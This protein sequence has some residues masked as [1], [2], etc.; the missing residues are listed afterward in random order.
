[1]PPLRIRNA[2]PLWPLALVAALGV[3]VALAGCSRSGGQPGG[4]AEAS[5][6]AV[7]SRPAAPVPVAT[8]VPAR[9]DAPLRFRHLT[10]DDGLSQNA[11]YATLQDRRGFFWFGTKDGL[12]RY[13]GYEFAVYRHDAA[14][15]ATLSSSQI[16][17][18]LED[19]E[20]LLWVG[21]H[22]GGLNR[23]DR[24]T[25]A[26]VR[27]ANSPQSRITA[28]AE[29]ARGG[30]WLGTAGEGVARLD[31]AD[32]GAPGAPFARLR[33]DP[34]DPGSLSHDDVNA[35]LPDRR[36]ALWIGTQAGLNR[37]GPGRDVTRFLPRAG[38]AGSLIDSTVS[39]LAQTRDG[40]LWV[41]TPRGLSRL[42]AGGR[43]ASA[44]FPEQRRGYGWASVAEIAEGPGGRLWL[45]THDGLARFD[46]PTGAY[47]FYRNGRSDPASVSGDF[48][49][50]VLWD[51]TGVLWA[52]TAGYGLNRY[53]AKTARFE[54]LRLPPD[55]V[56]RNDGFSVRSILEDTAGRVWIGAGVLYRVDPATGA[57]VSFETTSA[58]PADFGNARV[59]SMI[60][61]RDGAL[62]FGSVEGLYRLDPATERVRR[63]AV[64]PA[65]PG[66]LPGKD[67]FGVFEDRA[68]RIWAVT[69]YHLSRL[70]D[71]DS[72]R[73]TTFRHTPATEAD[74]GE[75]LFPSV[76]ED[77]AGRFWMATESGLLRLDPRTG[78]SRRF[79][80]DPDDPASLSND[81]V[82][83]VCPDP[84]APERVLWI[85]TAGGGLDRLDVRTGTFTH[86]TERDGLPNTVVYGVL[87]DAAGHLWIST[88]R[89]L[90]RYDPQTGGVRTYDVSD[91]LQSNE[92]N[93]GA[94]SRGPSGRLYFGGIN[95][96]T[97]FDPA[98]LADNPVAPAV[99]LTGLRVGNR[100]VAVGDS[101]GLLARA[102]W[103]TET[104]RLSPSENMVTFA[105]AALDASAPE[106]NRYAYRMEGFDA[107]WI[108]A[109]TDRT[110][111]YTNLPPGRYT[112]R[113]RGSN[114]DGVWNERGAALAIAVAPPW[115]RTW[116]AL[117][118]YA[119]LAA[120]ALRAVA[121]ER[122]RRLDL[123]HLAR[124][125]HAEAE[126]LRALDRAKSAF[127]ANVSHEFRTPLTLTL[128]PLDDAL[129]GEYGPVPAALAEPLGLARRSASRVLDLIGQILDL[130][131]LEAG[132]TPLHAR[133][134]D[135]AAFAAAQAQAFAPL[136][137]H[138]RIT[139]DVALPEAP[140]V[141]WFDPDHVGTVLT[142]VLS[143]A[144]KFTP[145]G[146]HVRVTVAQ[147]AREARVTV[148][149]TGPGIAPEDL[150]RVFDRFFQAD[151]PS[152]AGRP[153]GSGI[154]L[155][156]A[157]DLAALHGGT[158]TAESAAGRGSAFTLA[159]PRG[160]AH[161]TPAQLRLDPWDGTVTA[162][163][164]PAPAARTAG[165]AADDTSDDDVTTVLVADDN[166]DIRAYLR[167]HLEAAGYRV[168]EAAD[169]EEAL[170]RARAR[171][172]DLVVSDVMMPRLD[173]LGLCRALRGDPETD[174]VPVLLLTARATVEDRLDGL[175]E[176][177][178]DYLTKPFDVRELVA[179]VGN[180]IALRQRL[181]DRFAG[182][183][184]AG[185]GAAVPGAPPS[186]ALP[187]SADGTF[188]A[189]VRAAIEAHLGDDAFDVAALAREVGQ[190]RGSLLRRTT[191]LLGSSPSDLIRTTRLDRARAL[192]AARAG[193][194]S[195]VAYA[196]GFKSVAHFSNAFL[197]HTGS[198]P[199]AC[200]ARTP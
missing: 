171:L 112:F 141:V 19:R 185:D 1:M 169:G 65:R 132:R 24:A 161:L 143:N 179:R 186:L 111:T 177:C 47:T 60:Q 72:G 25:G 52:S 44:P 96:V 175:A 56:A 191:A 41:G 94:F 15:P 176:A 193:T 108:D 32:V 102:L 78:R 62:W 180:L 140:V 30:L 61:S 126:A 53:D 81:R 158:L 163:D 26:V 173:G 125:E 39:A 58:R 165:T 196:V 138:C 10:I 59:W 113:V 133:Q 139:T 167:R 145:E 66:G 14:A 71:A 87:P 118:L 74:A 120:A 90:A 46:P 89:G 77:A 155:A 69:R 34:G 7:A 70:D 157:H 21:T 100:P 97:S 23:L 148:R 190:S 164:P 189:A 45:A 92:F 2:L 48:L 75:A 51:R 144:F 84:R 93:A 119:G 63:Y 182:D 150:A 82:R 88:N 137:A 38:D 18:L 123:R 54:T 36:G 28:I 50:G 183:G 49:T 35:L 104:L 178:D 40:T 168:D 22:D 31:R 83:A 79:R 159:L 67:V 57:F 166:A 156:L 29:D 20:G 136:A 85:G 99:V 91:G 43:F 16:T 11:V 135:L 33:H 174:F 105:F 64:D 4:G 98:T 9:A 128:G 200:A 160:H 8:S 172:P 6:P 198:R 129:A 147:D 101:T 192:L 122:R 131:R 103:D 106:K 42:T 27:Y 121:R 134:A 55:V 80:A 199:S 76:H 95:G 5:R 184:A 194:V 197:A 115:W 181:R 3:A 151:E 68:G 152:P 110:A 188:V 130:S 114:N 117:L 107:R 170:A 187:S 12:N 116:W 153:Q 86:V 149:D 162:P 146:G 154:G 37:L 109:G 13:D 73:F 124:V 195:E 142:N 17:A 127:F